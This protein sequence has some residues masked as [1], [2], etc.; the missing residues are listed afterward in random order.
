MARVAYISGDVS[1]ARGDDPDDWQPANTNIPMTLGDRTWTAGGRLEL[2]VHGGNLIRLAPSTDLAALNLTEDTKQ[3][4]VS[5]GTRLISEPPPRRRRSLEVDTPNA[6]VTFERTGDYRID[7]RPN[8]NTRVQVRRGRAIVA[9]G[10]GQVSLDS[11]DAMPSRA[12]SRRVT[13]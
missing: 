1:F 12:T 2:Q 13:T 9:S 5:G 4:S 7:V 6:A 8:G 10:G 11:G 3:F